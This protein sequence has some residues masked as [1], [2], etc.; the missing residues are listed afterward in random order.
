MAESP[1]SPIAA[2][3]LESSRYRAQLKLLILDKCVL[4]LLLALA[5]YLFSRSLEK[6]KGALSQNLEA[7][8]ADQQVLIEA[9]RAEGA[10]ELAEL[11][12][13]H[14]EDLER[15]RGEQLRNLEIF[16]AILVSQGAAAK[17]RLEAYEAVG[18]AYGAMEQFIADM[19]AAVI[20]R[21]PTR[22]DPVPNS[23]TDEQHD[24]W[25][26]RVAQLGQTVGEQALFLD[27]QTLSD[28]DSLA[29]SFDMVRLKMGHGT[30]LKYSEQANKRLIN[31]RGRLRHTIQSLMDVDSTGTTS[32]RCDGHNSARSSEA[33]THGGAGTA[34]ATSLGGFLKQQR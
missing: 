28:Y 26:Q 22:A 34:D 30:D 19:Q 14:A 27:D 23:F 33:P 13:R 29:V 16:R 8:K 4:A 18:Q 15:M 32:P 3:E 20:T 25:V 24:L 21:Q 12:N 6:Y 10:R 11:N 7:Y 1:E 5:G 17:R 9:V 2:H 31:L